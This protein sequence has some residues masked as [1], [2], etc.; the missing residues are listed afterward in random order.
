MIFSIGHVEDKSVLYD[1]RS[2][3]SDTASADDQYR[4]YSSAGSSSSIHP[5][6]VLDMLYIE[7]EE[8]DNEEQSDYDIY[9]ASYDRYST[10]SAVSKDNESY[11]TA[12]DSESDNDGE[13]LLNNYSIADDYS[14]LSGEGRVAL[15]MNMIPYTKYCP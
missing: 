5:S 15:R 1:T 10:R 4:S 6:S 8:D 9:D 3:S 13:E 14:F 12:I 7:S 11:H 2:Y